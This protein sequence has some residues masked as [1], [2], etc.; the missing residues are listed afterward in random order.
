MA[1]SSFLFVVVT[2]TVSFDEVTGLFT[3][4]NGWRIGVATGDLWEYT[5][6]HYPQA[7]HTVDLN[8]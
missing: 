6:I 1:S 2:N 3:N 7:F 4:H 8:K 5:A